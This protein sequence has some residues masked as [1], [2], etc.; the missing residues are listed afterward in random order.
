MSSDILSRPIDV[1]RFGLIFAGAQKNLGP[2]GVTVVIFARTSPSAQR[3]KSAKI[4]QYRTSC[5]EKSLYNTPPTFGVYILGLVVDWI[6]REGGADG[7]G[8]ERRQSEAALRRN[9]LTAVITSARSKRNP[10]RR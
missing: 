3:Q 7:I 8:R 2:S 1:K 5:K 9:R 10:A 6:D 4:L